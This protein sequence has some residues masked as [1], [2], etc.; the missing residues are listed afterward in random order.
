M[1]P[2][3]KELRQRKLAED[4]LMRQYRRAPYALT[5]T[6]TPVL[7]GDEPVTK[8]PLPK[9]AGRAKIGK[10]NRGGRPKKPNALTPAQKQA[11]YRARLKAKT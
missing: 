4:R 10:V 6:V 9:P 7:Y 2:G 1:K 3:P 8:T 11:A 5:R